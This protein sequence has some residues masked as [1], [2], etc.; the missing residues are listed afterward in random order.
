[1]EVIRSEFLLPNLQNPPEDFTAMTKYIAKGL[2]CFDPMDSYNEIIFMAKRLI[3]VPNYYYLDSEIP[4]NFDRK[5]LEIYNQTYCDR[6]FIWLSVM[7]RQFL[8]KCFILRWMLNIITLVSEFFIR[9]FPFFA[10]IKFG[11]RNAYVNIRQ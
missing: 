11:I 2:W 3:G 7:T 9:Y 1:M 8:L 4:D 10:F 5:T 6:I